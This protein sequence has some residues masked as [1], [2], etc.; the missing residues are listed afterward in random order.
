[1]PDTSDHATPSPLSRRT[2]LRA[3]GAGIGLPLLDAMLP[4]L[5][6]RARAEVASSSRSA[7]SPKR[8][9]AI[10]VPLGMMPQFFFPETPAAADATE[11]SAPSSPYLDLLADHRGHFTTFSGLSHP[12]VDGNHH[13]AQC[14][15]TG[16]PGPGRPSFR[17][18]LSLDQFVV[19]KIGLDTRFPFLTLSVRKG[20]HYA[21]TLSVSRAGVDIPAEASP[22]A[23]Y[24]RLFVAG[25]PEEQA[26]S[27][28][29]IRAGG[30]VLDLVLDKKGRLERAV[31]PADRSRLDQYFTSVRE[32]EQRLKRSIEWEHRPKPQVDYA[33]PQDIADAA[34]IIEK[35]RL[36]FDLIRLAFE[37]DSTR[38]VTLSLSTFSIVAAV[39]GVKNETH[40]LT[41]HGNDPGKITELR[42]LEEAQLE[43]F[44]SL[45]TAFRGSGEHGQSLL[46]Q[47]AVLYGSCLGNANSHSNRNLPIILAGGGFQHP[48]HL[49]FDTNRNE[50][51]A[52]LFVSMLQQLSIEADS[53]ASS[54][55]TLRGLET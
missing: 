23:L 46:D 13:A 51:L 32:L 6:R 53:F 39:P 40:E 45:L 52:N 44:G 33:E 10:H 28:R 34:R 9:L 21:D 55:G 22:R 18:S 12:D 27:L 41:H 30:S 47:T 37:T 24:R 16:A 19:E 1:M 31:S 17:N 42:K 11:A 43:A 14:F 26:A 4:M 36:M 35:S 25:T 50:P 3:T 7:S 8:L 54:T 29:R 5:G 15:L 49:A 20:D 2:M 48:G 38:V